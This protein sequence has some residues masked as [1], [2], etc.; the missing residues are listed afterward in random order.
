M[1][2]IIVDLCIL[3]FSNLSKWCSKTKKCQWCCVYK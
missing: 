3:G 2:R 1:C